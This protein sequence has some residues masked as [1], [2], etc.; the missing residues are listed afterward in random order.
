MHI[1]CLKKLWENWTWSD[2]GKVFSDACAF[3]CLCS[4]FSFAYCLLLLLHA[5]ESY[6]HLSHMYAV[7][8]IYGATLMLMQ[9]R[10]RILCTWRSAIYKQNKKNNNISNMKNRSCTSERERYTKSAKTTATKIIITATAT[11]TWITKRYGG[12]TSKILLFAILQA[13]INVVVK[14][15][16]PSQLFCIAVSSFTF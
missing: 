16:T 8:F 11:T 12:A 4:I 2:C 14:L 10:V 15:R 1:K 3:F 7:P 6:N 5:V 13:D 9:T